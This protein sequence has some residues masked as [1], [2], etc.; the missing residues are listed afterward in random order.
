MLVQR[1]LG[2]VRAVDKILVRSAAAQSRN[3]PDGLGDELGYLVLPRE[4]ALQ[5]SDLCQ[6]AASLRCKDH[7][8]WRIL[9][10]RLMM[11][12]CTSHLQL[13]PVLGKALPTA[14]EGLTAA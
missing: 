6:I 11:V 2:V 1:H 5:K 10:F 7:N 8:I 3:A 14:G 9:R 4:K 12:I 13:S